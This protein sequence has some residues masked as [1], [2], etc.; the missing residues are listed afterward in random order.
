MR[1]TI[2]I[3]NHSIEIDTSMGWLFVY[4]STF[5]RDILPD[6][7]PL[8]EAAL[9]GLAEI[10]GSGAIKC[11]KSIDPEKALDLMNAD[12]LVDMLVKMAG[13]ELTTV[14]QVFWAMVKNADPYAAPPEAFF[15]KL[16]RF[17]M[18][19]VVPTMFYAIVES[20]V[21]SKNA[22]SLLERMRRQIPSLSTWSQSQE[23]TEG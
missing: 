4:K 7:M 1:R 16:E 3:D 23:S 14:L 15:G 2:N 17:P 20:S 5:G 10:L 18:D 11:D 21:S 19:E 12:A 22:K 13:M 8:V 6:L 9:S